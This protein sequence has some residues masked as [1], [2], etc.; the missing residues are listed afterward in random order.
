MKS[1][2]ENA[3]K[4]IQQPGK[5]QVKSEEAAKIVSPD[6][7]ELKRIVEQ[8]KVN[9]RI[10]GCGGGGSNTVTRIMREGIVGADLI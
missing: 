3:L 7:E 1:L 6:E 8:M 2:V 4:G 10:V 9:I 5:D